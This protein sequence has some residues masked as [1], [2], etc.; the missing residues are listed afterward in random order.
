[1]R[2]GEQLKEAFIAALNGNPEGRIVQELK[3][4]YSWAFIFP[5]V[6]RVPPSPFLWSC[7]ETSLVCPFEAVLSHI[8]M[9]CDFTDVSSQEG[10]VSCAINH[11]VCTITKGLGM[12]AHTTAGQAGKIWRCECN[13][14][15]CV[16]CGSESKTNLTLIS[17]IFSSQT[18]WIM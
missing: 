4:I 7:N 14:P 18:L 3:A 6:G 11:V 16:L 15:A 2:S 17:F 10:N 12:C 1:M 8:E 13:L 5:E 9:Y